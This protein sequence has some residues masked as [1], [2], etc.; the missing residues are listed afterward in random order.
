MFCFINGPL[1][2]KTF[3]LPAD[4]ADQA[5]SLEMVLMASC[6]NEAQRDTY[7]F[8]HPMKL[9]L[10]QKSP[11][12]YTFNLNQTKQKVNRSGQPLAGSAAVY[13]RVFSPRLL[14]IDMLSLRSS[15]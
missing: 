6:S 2:S 4:I 8:M 12:I 11:S 3:V 7:L 15:S 5:E 10:L 13:L 1:L 14:P 9:A